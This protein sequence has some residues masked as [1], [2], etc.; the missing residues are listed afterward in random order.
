MSMPTS[1]P[2]RGKGRNCIVCGKPFTAYG[3]QDTC[4]QCMLKPKKRI[5]EEPVN[6]QKRKCSHPGCSNEYEPTGNRQRF[7]PEH[8]P[9]P[10]KSKEKRVELD[11]QRLRYSMEKNT[12]PVP[13]KL[14]SGLMNGELILTTPTLSELVNQLFDYTGTT[15]ILLSGNGISIEMHKDS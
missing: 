15:A 10:H 13:P 8:R 14:E 3:A 1:R 7:C 9:A 6:I 12:S 2:P 4:T 5:M 11:R